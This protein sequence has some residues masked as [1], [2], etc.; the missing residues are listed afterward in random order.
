MEAQDILKKL[1]LI[2]KEKN[3]KIE[4]KAKKKQQKNDEKELFFKCKTK[5]ICKGV[6]AAKGLQQCPVCNEIK[7]SVCSKAACQIN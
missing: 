5:C 2:E 7:K 6:C 4:E 1:E 3:E